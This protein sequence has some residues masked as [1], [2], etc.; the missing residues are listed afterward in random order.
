ML[1]Y[2]EW[3]C[4]ANPHLPGCLALHWNTAQ[5]RM[6]IN[7]KNAMKHSSHQ[8]IVLTNILPSLSSKLNG[9]KEESENDLILTTTA[10]QQSNAA[11]HNNWPKTFLAHTLCL[12]QSN[13]ENW[14]SF[15]KTL[16]LG[17]H[18]YTQPD[19][20]PQ[21]QI[22][23]G[24]FLCPSLSQILIAARSCQKD[25]R[26]PRWWNIIGQGRW[27]VGHWSLPGSWRHSW[28]GHRRDS[29]KV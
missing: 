6:K 3:N 5:Q 28:N 10:H 4:Q 7:W 11:P 26:T 25:P 1:L 23:L 19:F 17:Y 29:W 27:N 22:L 12:F 9:K 13:F 8:K 14:I 24:P 18:W 20:K 16:V 2:E 15:Y 21:E